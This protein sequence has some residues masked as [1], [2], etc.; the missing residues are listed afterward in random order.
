M[1]KGY[2]IAELLITL[3]I[4]GI[5]SA[6][7]GATI[8][9]LQP[10][11]T[12]IRYLKR[13]DAVSK[14]INELVHDSKTFPLCQN[15]DGEEKWN[16]G[17]HPL[18]NTMVTRHIVGG[19]E[20]LC[21]A[22]SQMLSGKNSPNL[23]C[24]SQ[25]LSYSDGSWTPSFVTPNG[26]EWLVS[27]TRS[28]SNN[29]GTYQTDIYFDI[30]GS[31]GPNCLYSES[32]L[33]PDR[34]KL[35]VAADGTVQAA[36]PVGIK[37][38][39]K[40]K[41][42][43]KQKLEIAAGASVE[44]QLEESL[45]RFSLEKCEKSIEEWSW[46]EEEEEGTYTPK[47]SDYQINARLIDYLTIDK[48]Y[49]NNGQIYQRGKGWSGSRNKAYKEGYSILTSDKMKYQFKAQIKTML[50]KHGIPFESIETIFES[51]YNHSAEEVLNTEGMITGRGARGLS[52]QGK[53]Y[54]NVKTM[55]DIFVS[56]FNT[57][58]CKS[59]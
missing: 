7:L 52:S 41:N 9:K 43:R 26:T 49:F 51:V 4:I 12:K 33:N 11:E 50:N 32:C 8:V 40:R 39:E 37:Y 27:T 59:L 25:P 13:Y 22:L 31:A 17:S 6:L 30:N 19:D 10:N 34:F 46:K 58:I 42:L 56:T 23:N 38:L 54:I 57:N 28:V 2:T 35:M 47:C 55:I 20:K 21:S 5:I 45:R 36:D 53:A 3:G 18:F 48:R 1:N 14:G 44:E 15:T 16:C 29:I 24:G